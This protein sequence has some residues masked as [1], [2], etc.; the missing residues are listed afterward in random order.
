MFLHMLLCRKMCLGSDPLVHGLLCPIL[1]LLFYE[2]LM[3]GLAPLS[4]LRILRLS[5]G[6]LRKLI[7]ANMPGLGDSSTHG[8][9]NSAAE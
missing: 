3:C 4:V 8:R 5:H 9:V 7:T 1:V 6:A 2:L